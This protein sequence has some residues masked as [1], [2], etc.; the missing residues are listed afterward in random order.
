MR[1]GRRPTS[2]KSFLSRREKP[3]PLLNLGFV[4]RASP[5]RA[6]RR[7]GIVCFLASVR[8]LLAA[9]WVGVVR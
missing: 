1:E 9:I 7:G 4:R 2:P 5:R 3:V 8:A 6:I